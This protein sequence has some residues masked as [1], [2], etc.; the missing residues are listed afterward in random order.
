VKKKQ[1]KKKRLIC[2]VESR[3]ALVWVTFTGQGGVWGRRP[4][5]NSKC[6]MVPTKKGKK[7]VKEERKGGPEG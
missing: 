6:R 7:G 3:A 1:N 4:G 5:E 2:G